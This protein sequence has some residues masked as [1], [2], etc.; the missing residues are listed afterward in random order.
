MAKIQHYDIG[1]YWLPEATFSV[2]GTATDPTTLQVKVRNPGGTITT[3]DYATPATLLTSSTPVARISAGV[4]RLIQEINDAG[5]WDAYFKGTGAAATAEHHQ[6]VGDP[7]PFF[8]S[9]QIG[10]RA[11]VSL[12]EARDWLEHSTTDTSDDLELARVI[13]DVSDRFHYEAQREFI[14]EG[15]NP[16]TRTF[17]M[18]ATAVRYGIVKVGDMSAITTVELLDTD[19]STVLES[20]IAAN[21]S[22]LP[23]ARASWEPIRRIQLNYGN[24]ASYL[25][26]GYRV[27]VT[28][29][30]GFPAVP[31]NVRQ[32][33][34]DAIAATLDRDVEHYKQDNAFGGAAGQE[35]STVVVLGRTGGKLLSMPASSLAVALSYRDPYLG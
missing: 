22:A 3:Y 33:V 17:E 21:Y 1:E 29:S 10:T 20:V 14:V 31:G 28:G 34:L 18:D 5:D 35:G 32:A 23:L 4:Y 25:R 19:W 24:G 9:A 30:W 12:A 26:P 16:Q 27:R 11:L 13:N 6:A 15:T 2:G 8:E 7:S